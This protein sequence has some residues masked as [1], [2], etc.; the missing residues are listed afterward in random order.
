M[1]KKKILYYMEVITPVIRFNGNN[2]YVVFKINWYNPLTYILFSFFGV[3]Q[4]I[5]KFINSLK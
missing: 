4:L 3:Q 5:Y 1:K 2:D